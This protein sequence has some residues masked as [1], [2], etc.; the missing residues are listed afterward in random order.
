MTDSRRRSVLRHWPFL[1]AA[2]WAAAVAAG[3]YWE[4]L[5]AWVG[6]AL[7]GLCVV[8]FVLHGGDKWRATRGGRRVPELVLHLF[9]LLGGWPGA[10]L[11]RHLFRHKTAKV[12]YRLVFW[13]CA[14]ANAVALGGYLWFGDGF[15]DVVRDDV[16]TGDVLPETLGE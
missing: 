2:G 13:L 7:L 11:S 9:E 10:L 1:A 14:A 3:V 6:W 15:G 4:R 8:A 5:P 12:S 16:L